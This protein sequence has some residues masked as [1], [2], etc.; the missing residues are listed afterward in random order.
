VAIHEFDYASGQPYAYGPAKVIALGRHR[1]RSRV[2]SG[3]VCSAM[4]L[5]SLTVGARRWTQPAAP[6][7]SEAATNGDIPDQIRKLA[8][9][10]DHGL[11]T[12]EELEAKKP[13]LLDRL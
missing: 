1:R 4:R 9:L 13:E 12:E 5:P 2:E 10:R 3:W 8:E 6:A 7:T 11:L